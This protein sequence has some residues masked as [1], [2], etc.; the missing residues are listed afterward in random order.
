MYIPQEFYITAQTHEFSPYFIQDVNMKM[1]NKFS[2]IVFCH[3]HFWY[4]NS[5]SIESNDHASFVK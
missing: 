4:L 1:T 2:K 5:I 3:F